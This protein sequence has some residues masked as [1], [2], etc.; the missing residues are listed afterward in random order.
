MAAKKPDS[1][2][3]AL[4][5][6]PDATVHIQVKAGE[7]VTYDGRVYGDRATLQVPRRYLVHVDGEY[8]ELKSGADVPD[9]GKW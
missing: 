6:R 3:Q 9:V 2:R 4:R 1:R 7:T 8:E 5:E